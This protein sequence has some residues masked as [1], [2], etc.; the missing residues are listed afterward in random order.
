MKAARQG[1][2]CGL[3]CLYPEFDNAALYSF[4]AMMMDCA[5][6][7][8][9]ALVKIIIGCMRCSVLSGSYGA[10]SQNSNKPV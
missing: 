10:D 3:P 9:M 8:V 1:N 5:S 6:H 2:N 4:I 7:K